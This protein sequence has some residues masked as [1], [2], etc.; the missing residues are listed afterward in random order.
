MKY[1]RNQNFDW[2]VRGLVKITQIRAFQHIS[3]KLCKT[4]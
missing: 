3:T 1:V 4:F 2:H